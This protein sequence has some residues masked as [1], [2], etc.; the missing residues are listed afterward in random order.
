MS[1]GQGCGV[2]LLDLPLNVGRAPGGF[3]HQ[4]RVGEHLRDA[5]IE[6]ARALRGIGR[7]ARIGGQRLLVGG[8]A[9]QDLVAVGR[10]LLHDSLW[11]PSSR[12]WAAAFRLR[13]P[14]ACPCRCACSSMSVLAKTRIQG[15]LFSATTI[16][17]PICTLSTFCELDVGRDVEPGDAQGRGARAGHGLHLLRRL[18]VGEGGKRGADQRQADGESANAKSSR[19]FITGKIIV[20]RRYG[21]LS[22]STWARSA[23]ST[24]PPLTT[25][26]ALR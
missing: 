24:L 3:G 5:A 6:Q 18:L 1:R 20:E 10:G 19:W 23:G 9:H 12:R 26:T 17:R 25:A 21:A 15:P 14:S 7:A 8:R 13:R 4:R 22:V 2:G 11:P 16:S